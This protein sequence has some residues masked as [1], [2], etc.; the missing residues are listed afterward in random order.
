[1]LR[2]EIGRKK[3]K[4][5][6]TLKDASKWFRYYI[7][8][9]VAILLLG[10]I[11]FVGIYPSISLVFENL[12]EIDELRKKSEGLGDEI[13]ALEQLQ[14]GQV[15]AAAYLQLLDEIIPSENTEV[16]DYQEN[17]KDIAQENGLRLIESTTGET[18]LLSDEE[19]SSKLGLIEVPSQFTLQGNLGDI[20]N[21][22]GGLDKGDDFIV[23][24]EMSLSRVTIDEV[25]Q[26]D[27]VLEIVF[28]K[29]QF[30]EVALTDATIFE[31][32]SEKASPNEE[33]LNF[34]RDRF[35]EGNPVLN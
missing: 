30:Q 35:G 13:A 9:I 24:N 27:W 19:D 5:N 8:P 18:I 11:G 1:M 26:S 25:E 6:F 3:K 20:K 28:V 32:I 31:D 21:F 16:V 23:I 7:L 12:D 22:L 33:V 29:Y 4:K 17:I 15:R 2:P 34:M 10:S 14:A